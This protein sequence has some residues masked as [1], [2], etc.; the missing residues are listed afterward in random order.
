M[1]VDAR[2]VLD[3]FASR[4]IE[5]ARRFADKLAADTLNAHPGGH[6]NSIAW[7]LWHTA[8]EIDVQ[9]AALSS[10]DEVWSS[11]G[12]DTRFDLGEVGNSVGYGHSSAEA[13]AVVVDDATLLLDYL[14]ATTDALRSYIRSLAPDALGEVIDEDWD[15]PVTR[16]ARIVSIIDDAAQHIGQAAYAAGIARG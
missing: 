5:T 11:Q 10:S 12:F 9:V 8:R 16:A 7:L 15:P 3:E 4:P 14:R 1:S 13:R 2:D 6:D